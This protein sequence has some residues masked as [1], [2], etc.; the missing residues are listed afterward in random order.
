MASSSLTQDL[1]LELKGFSILWIF[2][3]YFIRLWQSFQSLLELVLL[4]NSECIKSIPAQSTYPWSTFHRLLFQPAYFLSWQQKLSQ[5]SSEPLMTWI[6]ACW[7][8]TF[9]WV[10]TCSS[11]FSLFVQ[12]GWSWLGEGIEFS[13]TSFMSL[14]IAFLIRLSGNRLFTFCSGLLDRLMTFFILVIRIFVS[15]SSPWYCISWATF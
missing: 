5:G 12:L 10:K 14:V 4:T 7:V 15:F 9:P 2:H 6:D 3:V 13:F 1:G 11:S 8:Q